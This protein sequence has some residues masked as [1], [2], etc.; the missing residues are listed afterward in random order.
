M[1]YN[2]FQIKDSKFIHSS[3]YS[4]KSHYISNTH[5]III[6]IKSLLMQKQINTYFIPIKCSWNFRLIGNHYSSLIRHIYFHKR[7]GVTFCF[8]WLTLVSGGQIQLF[9]LVF[10]FSCQRDLLMAA[11]RLNLNILYLSCFKSIM[12]LFGHLSI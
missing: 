5:L 3:E 12:E 9:L 10:I 4:D 2:I 8:C 6:W 11:K 7:L 1:R